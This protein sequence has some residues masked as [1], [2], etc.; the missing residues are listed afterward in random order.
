MRVVET[1]LPGVFIVEP[2]L[3]PDERGLFARTFSRDV[4]SEHGL[5]DDFVQGNLSRNPK[6]GTL[7]GLHFQWA[8]HDEVKLV[9]C[10]KGRIFDVAVDIRRGSA[11]FGQWVGQILDS[12]EAKALYVPSG[13]AH[14]FQTLTPDAEVAYQTSKAY[15]PSHIGG[16]RWNDPDIAVAWP[17][18][19]PCA[20]SD[21]DQS[22]PLLR[23]LG[24]GPG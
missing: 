19:R 3:F 18:Q 22:L 15:Q 23:D 11:T 10:V 7:R 13:F 8:P 4:L 12:E 5:H 1:T 6:A 24:H 17:M 2:D 9:R 20:I 21:R 14:G 16:V